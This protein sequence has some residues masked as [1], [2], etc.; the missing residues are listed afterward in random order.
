MGPSQRGAEERRVP[1]GV[2]S[3]LLQQEEHHPGGRQKINH[4]VIQEGT[5]RLVLDLQ[6]SHEESQDI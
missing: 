3:L 5:Q 4:H 2:Y 1:L 6:A